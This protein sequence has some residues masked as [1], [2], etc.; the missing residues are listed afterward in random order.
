MSTIGLVP[1]SAPVEIT[2]SGADR[3]AVMRT[4][5]C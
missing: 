4:A 2:L 5:H 1:R 3:R